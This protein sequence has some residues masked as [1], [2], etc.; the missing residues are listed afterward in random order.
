MLPEKVSRVWT[1]FSESDRRR[2]RGDFMTI[3]GGRDC[4]SLQL[5]SSRAGKELWLSFDWNGAAAKFDWTAKRQKTFCWFYYNNGDDPS[6]T[7]VFR[8]RFWE[9]L[10]V[11]NWAKA[12]HSFT[13]RVS[14]EFSFRHFYAGQT[15]KSAYN[16]TGFLYV[17]ST[18]FLS[19]HSIQKISSN[20]LFSM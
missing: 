5:L 10:P 9:L 16:R 17:E 13:N 11:A 8:T 4:S 18:Y 1:L 7:H 6:L 19:P 14:N 3:L 2:R 15:V 20:L 12:W